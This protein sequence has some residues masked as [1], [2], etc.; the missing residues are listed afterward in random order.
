MS[1]P[2]ERM[3]A[4]RV[5][6]VIVIDDANDAL[7]LADALAEG[8]LPCAEITF[9]TAG[10]EE[11]LRRIAGERPEIVVGAG[12]VLTADQAQRA[13]DAGARFIV[14]PVTDEVVI[15]KALELGVAAMPGTQT[16]TEMWRA[17]NAGA[18]LCKLFPVTAGG[19]AHVRSV[20]GPMPFVKIVPTNGVDESNAADYLNAG[21]HA[22]GFVATLFEAEAVRTGDRDRIA[23]RARTLLASVRSVD[24]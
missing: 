19:P 21:C 13:V 20:L 14:S 6:P 18:H 23:S 11:A 16:P 22:I 9:R 2:L 7:P 15:G 10:A 17:H 1:D 3:R 5:V 8:G 24:R 4:M 12:T